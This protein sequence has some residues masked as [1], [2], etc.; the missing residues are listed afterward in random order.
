MLKFP[1]GSGRARYVAQQ[2]KRK[3]TKKAKDIPK[4]LLEEPKSKENE[5]K[6]NEKL[7]IKQESERGQL[8]DA[9]PQPL[10]MP[11]LDA[12][13]RQLHSDDECCIILEDILNAALPDSEEDGTEELIEL[14]SNRQLK[15]ASCSELK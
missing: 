1:V 3:K 14:V 13:E 12:E 6:I 7:C 4:Q 10:S 2:L 11:N 8:D 15:R 9:Q 5:N